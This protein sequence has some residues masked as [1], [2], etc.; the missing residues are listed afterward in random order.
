VRP[1]VDHQRAMERV[2]ASWPSTGISDITRGEQRLAAEATIALVKKGRVPT[3][4]IS[5]TA[6][7]LK[8]MAMEQ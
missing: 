4:V 2:R 3:A 8:R 1:F 5:R 6:Q 7:I